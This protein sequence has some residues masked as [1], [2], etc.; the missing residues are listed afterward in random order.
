LSSF[1][2]EITTSSDRW[3]SVHV[4]VIG[5]I[6]RPLWAIF[7]EIGFFG[8]TDATYGVYYVTQ[9]NNLH[10]VDVDADNQP[11]VVAWMNGVR[12]FLG[13]ATSSPQ[14]LPETLPSSLPKVVPLSFS[15]KSNWQ[16]SPS[17]FSSDSPLPQP[18]AIPK[19]TSSLIVNKKDRP[20]QAYQAQSAAISAPDDPS[21]SSPH[22]TP[23]KSA[24][25]SSTRSHA[26]PSPQRSQT[27]PSSPASDMS[28]QDSSSSRRSDLGWKR[29][30]E[31]L[32]TR[33]ELL[34]SLMAS[35]AVI[36]CREFSI[37]G[38]EEV[39]ELKKVGCTS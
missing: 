24:L 25:K 36:D 14:Q 10:I 35:E 15:S 33:D 6:F 5:F 32:T 39:E 12:R 9:L 3:E 11:S 8:L 29:D 37:L 18:D 22:S 20:K 2:D 19:T 16:S 17:P 34:I 27:L 1:K 13:S 38:T 28:L 31:S 26:V 4:S 21:R 7:A 23:L 30:S